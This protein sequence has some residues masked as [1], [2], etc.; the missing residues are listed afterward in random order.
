VVKFECYNA[1]AGG[2]EELVGKAE[3]LMSEIMSE[4]K[5]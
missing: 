4:K 3:A 2:A 5:N 1:D